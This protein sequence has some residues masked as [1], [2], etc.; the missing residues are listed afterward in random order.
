MKKYDKLMNEF[1]GTQA[2]SLV[3]M[4]VVARDGVKV[5]RVPKVPEV[6]EERKEQILF[7]DPRDSGVYMTSEVWIGS[8][9]YTDLKTLYQEQLLDKKSSVG[10][11]AGKLKYAGKWLRCELLFPGPTRDMTMEDF[12]SCGLFVNE[13]DFHADA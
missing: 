10:I 7:Y 3:K 6:V 5:K 9:K 2:E 4:V 12:D 1:Q 13:E 11:I 8:K